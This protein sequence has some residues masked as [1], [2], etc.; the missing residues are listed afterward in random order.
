MKPLILILLIATTMQIDTIFKFENTSD[1]TNWTVVNDAVMGGKSSGAFTLNETGHGVYTGH[2]SLENNGGFSS[3]RYRFNDISTEGFSKVILKIKGDGKNYQFRVKSKLT[4]KHS[5]IALFS[6]SKT[7]EVI[8][9]SLADMYPAFRGRKLDIPNF[10]ANSIEE[11]AFLIGNKTAEDFKLE[12]DSI[13]L[14]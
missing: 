6:S 10:D 5:Y 7:W 9:I 2:V 11:V 8:E 12:I 4:D 14:K 13:V 1:I 3:L